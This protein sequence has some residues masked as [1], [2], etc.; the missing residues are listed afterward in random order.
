MRRGQPAMNAAQ[1]RARNRSIIAAFCREEKVKDIAE[2]HDV[3][4]RYVS[5]LA[6]KLD[7]SRPH[8]RPKALP[9]A[10]EGQREEYRVFRNRYGA[11]TARQMV[12][13]SQ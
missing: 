7:L 3:S 4:P 2:Q 13:V 8:G 5:M 6:A 9:K 11:A 10:S 1:R 12:G